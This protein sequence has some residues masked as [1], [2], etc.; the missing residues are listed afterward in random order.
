MQTCKSDELP[1]VT[2][3]SKTLDVGFLVGSA[4]GSLPVERR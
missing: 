1:A 4:H 3:L 2:K